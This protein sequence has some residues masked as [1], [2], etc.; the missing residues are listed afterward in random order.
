MGHPQSGVFRQRE[1]RPNQRRRQ[2]QGTGVSVHTGLASLR[3]ADSRG[4]CLYMG[5][6][7]SVRAGRRE[8]PLLAEYARNGAPAAGSFHGTGATSNSNGRGRPFYTGNLSKSGGARDS[9]GWWGVYV[10]ERK[11]TYSF[12]AINSLHGVPVR[13]LGLKGY[14]SVL[15]RSYRSRR[16]AICTRFV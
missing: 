10:P 16:C 13:R 2:R 1:Q 9:G 14:K 7:F 6:G 8:S 5:G 15:D 3:S 11:D 12:P 4:G